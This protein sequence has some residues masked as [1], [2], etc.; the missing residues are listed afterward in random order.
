MNKK[1]RHKHKNK[2]YYSLSTK[3]TWKEKLPIMNNE[4][5][6]MLYGIASIGLNTSLNNFKEQYYKNPIKLYSSTEYINAIGEKQ[7][8][9]NDMDL[10]V[11]NNNLNYLCVIIKRTRCLDTSTIAYKIQEEFDNRVIKNKYDEIRYIANY[12]KNNRKEPIF[13][14]SPKYK[15][16]NSRLSTM[17]LLEPTSYIIV[18]PN[19]IVDVAIGKEGAEK[20]YK[21]YNEESY[22]NRERHKENK[23]TSNQK[24]RILKKLDN[25]D[26][27][28]GIIHLFD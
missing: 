9:K 20:L 14:F 8:H 6:I 4:K 28:K 10:N 27:I 17:K 15:Q 3:C 2:V 19:I 12:C 11:M 22:I 23:N 24:E 16:I 26:N 13:C 1:H 25:I 18:N 7:Q 21:K 5:Y